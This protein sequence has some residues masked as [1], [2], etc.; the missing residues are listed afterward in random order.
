MDFGDILNQWEGSRKTKS[1]PGN[2]TRRNEMEDLLDKYSRP[3]ADK[4]LQESQ[5][6]P[7]EYRKELL[8]MK[9]EAEL[10]LH[11]L[12][13]EDAEQALQGFI[14]ESIQQ[15][16]KKVLIIHGKGHHSAERPV[17]MQLVRSFV[18]KHPA[19]GESGYAKGNEGGKGAVW[20]LLRYRSR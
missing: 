4:D 6:H 11:G 10:D 17:L 2:D 7:G 12:T 3:G 15:G 16:L 14:R 8:R 13:R 9:P 1:S 20:I 19:C 5:T 18:E